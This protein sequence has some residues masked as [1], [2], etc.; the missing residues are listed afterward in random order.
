[1]SRKARA[2]TVAQKKEVYAEN[3]IK[4]DIAPKSK[5]ISLDLVPKT[6]AQERYICNLFDE[7]KN[8]VVAYGPAGTGKTYLAMLAAIK[9][10]RSGECRKLVLT[11][12]AVGVEEEEHGAL[13]GTLVEKMAPWT[14]PLFDVL[15][16]YYRPRE[17]VSMVED[18]VI[19]VAPL[20]F[21]RGRSL[22]NAW[23]ITDEMQNSTTNQMK[24]L[25]T[26]IGEGSKIVVTGDLDQR[27]RKYMTNNGLDDIVAKIENSYTGSSLVTVKFTTKDIQRH[28]VV[29]EVLSLYK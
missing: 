13:P 25:L 20:A 3:T 16:Q 1:M 5:S 11:R 14:R 18:E 10:L 15:A 2:A 24:M 29:A 19:E 21:M 8:I 9:A 23:I 12:P 7:T 28:P 22:P 4:L 27:D 17:I 6:L 26:R